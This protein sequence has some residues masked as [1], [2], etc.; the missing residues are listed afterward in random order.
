MFVTD[1]GAN[2]VAAAKDVVGEKRHFICVDHTLS[3][4]TTVAI[5]YSPQFEDLLIKI[6]SIV[7]YFKRSVNAADA[8]R[9][10]QKKNGKSEGEVLKL[11]KDEP[12]R[13]GSMYYMLERFI[14]LA[15]DVGVVLLRHEHV[16]MLSGSELL[17]AKEACELLHPVAHAITELEGEEM[18]ISGKVIPILNIMKRVCIVL[19]IEIEFIY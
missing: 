9:A 18:S 6:R 11:K 5:E 8:L 1:G 15:E 3:R 12:T 7:T 16:R 17:A 2:I 4:M 14:L 10:I 19:E 13:W